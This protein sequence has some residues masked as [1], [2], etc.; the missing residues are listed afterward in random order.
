M[1]K[2][3]PIPAFLLRLL[4]PTDW[5]ETVLDEIAE[6][7]REDVDSHGHYFARRALWREISSGHWFRLRLEARRLRR[8]E[9]EVSASVWST[10]LGSLLKDV[11]FASRLM[12]RSPGFTLVAVLTLGLGIGASSAI[13]SVVNGVLLRSLPLRTPGQLVY[14]WDRLEWIGFPRASVAGPQV[15]E[16]RQETT[17]FDGFAALRTGTAQITGLDEPEEIAAA[18]GSANLFGLLGVQAELGRTFLDGDDLEGAERIVV[19]TDGLWR[20]HFGGDPT[21]L[22]RSLTLDGNPH[23]IVGVLP[24]NFRFLI[25]HSLSQPSAAEVWLPD[26]TDLAAAQRGQHRYAVLARIKDGVNFE[27]AS[28]ELAALGETQDNQWFGDNGFTYFA[29]PVQEDLVKNVRPTLLLLLAAVGLLL[30]IAAANIATLMLARSQSRARE[31]SVRAALGATRARIVWLAFVEAG[32]LAAIGGVLGVL[33]AVFAINWLVSLAPAGLPRSDE[34]T[35][36]GRI[37]LFAGTI[38]LAAAILCSLAPALHN[39]RQRLMGAFNDG[40]R[41]L[42]GLGTAMRMRQLIVIAEIAL[43]LMLLTGAGLLVRSLALM[44]TADPGFTP[45]HVIATDISLPHSRYADALSRTRFFEAL[46]DRLSGTP[47]I[48]HVSTTGTLPLG[49]AN[50]NQ[51]DCRPDVLPEDVDAVMA[52]YMPVSPDYFT[53]MGIELVAGRF[54]TPDDD[55]REAAPFVA[56]ID[57][58]LARHWLDG[59]AVGRQISHLGEEW[60]V[61][62]VVRHARIEQVYEDDRPQIYAPHAQL[63]F[64]AMTLVV[65]SSIDP[66]VLVPM[67]RAVVKEIDSNQPIA[68]VRTMTGLVSESTAKQRFSA[69]LMTVFAF[70]GS[71]LAVL[72]VY[73]VLSY[74]VSSRSREIG[75][76]R[77]LGA[78]ESGVLRLVIRQGLLMTAAGIAVGL[79]GAFAL[80]RAMSGMVFE[81][82]SADPLTFVLVPLGLFVIAGVACLLP[83]RKA[84]RLDPLAVLRTE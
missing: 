39:S 30:L 10:S 77:A 73:G 24:R 59:N 18:F 55:E 1:T 13:F 68:N 23:T 64:R 47:G 17:L 22:G 50:R 7:Y 31:I 78:Q 42:V 71:L 53:T 21:V 74:S 62:G 79:A 9:S 12:R 54:F 4:L 27:Q 51:S 70:A 60:T 43:S 65:N 19:L 5:R 32:L 83:A 44:T 57:Q 58:K 29:V 2:L 36:D 38:T 81:I 20:R 15:A 34:V 8:A 76:R 40:G 67:V 26:P 35:V 45:E 37:V 11:T 66:T 41:G 82:S 16:L 3:P 72:G 48:D 14:V 63:P 75:I 33:V 61:V 25:H 80:S 28:A 56:I 52:D 6:V 46:I 49:Y 84:S 69:T